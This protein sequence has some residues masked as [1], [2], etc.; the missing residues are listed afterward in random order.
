MCII[1]DSCTIPDFFD[2]S[3]ADYEPIR[4][5]IYTKNGKMVVGGTKYSSELRKLS[6]YLRLIAELSRQGRVVTIDRDSVDNAQREIK[7]IEPKSD[8]NDPHIVALVEVSGCRI[9]CT[10]D[11]K[12]D[13][14]LKDNRFYRKA[15]KPSIYKNASHSHLLCDKNIVSVCK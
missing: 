10:L 3:N 8:F 1:I 12:S 15:K 9:V 2:S 14:Y 6:K 11:N 13:K 7:I 4:K 5:W